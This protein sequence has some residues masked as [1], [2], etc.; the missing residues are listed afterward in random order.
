MPKVKRPLA[1]PARKKTSRRPPQNGGATY[2]TT[3]H[4]AMLTGL[5]DPF[6]AE[7]ANARYPD[8]GAGRSLTF[9]QR[10]AFPVVSDANGALAFAINPRP[11]FP[12]LATA[13]ITGNAATWASTW[14]S[15]GDVS[16]NLL[17]AYGRFYRPT[18]CGVRI[19]NTLSA[20]ASSGYVIIAKGGIPTLGSSTTFVPSNFTNFDFHSMEQGGEW[21]VTSHPRA[22][23]AYDMSDI[24]NFAT[25][26]SKGDETWETI[27]VMAL[28][29]VASTAALIVEVFINYEYT[30]QEDAAIAQ[31]A[32]P[33]P[34]LNVGMQ[35]AI[36]HVQSASPTSHKNGKAAVT[37]FIKREGKKALVKHVIPF[38]AKKGTALLV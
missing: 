23:D 8:S 27:Y 1:K 28:G 22:A 32:A 36:N 7:A 35:T 12:I 30:A 11:N 24:T 31:L 16:S 19:A 25:N 2:S 18:S 3:E 4:E 33:Q 15:L 5:T 10:L 38:L 13:S 9:Q 20:T 17:N 6:S 26:N 29:V 14:S 34:V 21:H 37:A